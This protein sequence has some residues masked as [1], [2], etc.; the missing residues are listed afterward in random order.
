VGVNR[1]TPPQH[2]LVYTEA[3][4]PVL[5][6][7]IAQGHKEDMVRVF[8]V[9]AVHGCL[10]VL[11]WCEA[12]G[13][14]P[15]TLTSKELKEL[16]HGSLGKLIARSFDWFIDHGIDMTG[17]DEFMYEVAKEEGYDEA[18][19]IDRQRVSLN[20]SSGGYRDDEASVVLNDVLGVRVR[21][22]VY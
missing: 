1:N 11:D 5:N 7:L 21:L 13:L 14:K 19:N 4:L 22:C 3:G 8:H 6:W 16:K 9:A 2:K 18:R 17:C 12:N 15:A 20:W 10:P